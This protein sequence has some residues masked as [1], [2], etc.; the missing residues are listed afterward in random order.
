MIETMA[1]LVTIGLC[2][3]NC[4]KTISD[5][6]ESIVNQDFPSEQTE[7][8]VVDDGCIDRT[9][10]MAIDTL[11]KA[12][13]KVRVFH[14]GGSGLGEARQM[15]VDNA[16]G[17]YV[18]WVDG[19]ITLSR[20]HERRQV[21]FMEKHP[22]VGKAR[23][24]WRWV[25]TGSLAAK[26]EGMRASDL[27][28]RHDHVELG[29]SKLVGIGGSI[30]RLEAL[31]QVGGFDKCITGAGEDIDLA[32]KMMKAGWELS[33]S[34]GEFFHRTK[35]TWRDLWAQYFWYG[36]GSHFVS[37]RYKG[38]FPTWTRT[39]PVIFL[40]GLAHSSIAYRITRRKMCFLLP[41]QYVFKNTAWYLGFAKAHIESYGHTNIK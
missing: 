16:K 24:K 6:V 4:E 1:V 21:E 18:I 17:K 23:G 2:V 33:F 20:D 25:Q 22:N 14:T 26:L 28:P 38:V 36:Y 7:V 11:S 41:L 30:C 5:T 12:K 34:E 40:L 27:K 39:P 37:H 13:M 10:P 32:A 19:D 29:A 31:K 8:I 35:E 15:V 3:K 9:L